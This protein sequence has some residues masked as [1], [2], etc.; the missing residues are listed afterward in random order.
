ML[1]S[2]AVPLQIVEK[3]AKMKKCLMLLAVLWLTFTA[4]KVWYL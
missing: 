1:M 2:I 4:G 3:S